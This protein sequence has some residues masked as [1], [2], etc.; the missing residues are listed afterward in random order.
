M[1]R[2]LCLVFV[3]L[4]VLAV[5]AGCSSNDDLSNDHK[6]PDNLADNEPV[7]VTQWPENEYTSQIIK[8]EYGEM[9]YV[10]DNSDFGRYALFLKNISEEESADYI[11]TLKEHGFAE[12]IS[13]GN[14]VSS[15][16]ILQKDK[17]TL[18]IA[19]SNGSLGME[20]TMEGK[21]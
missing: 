11:E 19:Y 3:L 2:N 8:P 7:Y 20:I 9:D 18:S 12:L 5:S 17:V 4:F 13:E 15:G 21:Q 6:I 14:D 16:T 10:Y 1:K